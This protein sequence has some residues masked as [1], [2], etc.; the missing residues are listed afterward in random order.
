LGRWSLQYDDEENTHRGHSSKSTREY[1]PASNGCYQKTHPLVLFG[2]Y[3]IALV[4]YIPKTSTPY[5]HLMRSLPFTLIG[6][7]DRNDNELCSVDKNLFRR[8][9]PFAGYL[10]GYPGD[11]SAEWAP[12]SFT[13]GKGKPLRH[14]DWL[15]TEPLEGFQRWYSTGAKAENPYEP[16]Y[17]PLRISNSKSPVLDTLQEAFLENNVVIKNVLML[18]MESTRKDVFP[19]KKDSPLHNIVLSSYEASPGLELLGL[20]ANISRAS[21]ILSGESSGF[22]SIITKENPR[23]W[24]N[25]GSNLGVSTSTA[26]YPQVHTL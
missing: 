3:A 2:L 25:L 20:L 26:P 23:N 14:V 8:P 15:P 17:D 22:E 12:W 4:W 11:S 5:K 13:S 1:N 6:D 10:E 16:R 19:F 21:E 9:F 24:T 18:T 7:F